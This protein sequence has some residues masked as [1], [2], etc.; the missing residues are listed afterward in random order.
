MC[1]LSVVSLLR[2]GLDEKRVRGERVKVDQWG[3]A[4]PATA[5]CNCLASLLRSLEQGHSPAGRPHARA[6]GSGQQALEE[7]T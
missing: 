7:N 3:L 6:P 2:G 4:S 5:V 1:S